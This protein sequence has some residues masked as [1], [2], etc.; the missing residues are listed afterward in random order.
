MW[1]VEFSLAHRIPVACFSCHKINKISISCL[2]YSR[3]QEIL[4]KNLLQNQQNLKAR[5]IYSCTGI[6]F[7]KSALFTPHY[8]YSLLCYKIKHLLHIHHLHNI[9]KR[10]PRRFSPGR[11]PHRFLQRDHCICSL[12]RNG[13][14]FSV[15]I[16]TT[17]T[18]LRSLFRPYIHLLYFNY[19]R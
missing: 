6:Y 1:L 9:E 4:L 10:S 3:K 13:N 14:G 15:S 17:G 19:A 11:R 18:G 12:F 2:N 7:F 5:G 8:T 16:P